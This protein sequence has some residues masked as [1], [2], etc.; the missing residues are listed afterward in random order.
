M[1]LAT[2][3]VWD[4]PRPAMCQPF[5]GTLTIKH[6]DQ[7][8]AKSTRAYR[9]IETSHPPAYYFPPE[10]ISSEC[11]K[12]NSRTSFCEWKGKAS[13]IDLCIGDETVENIGWVYTSPTASFS[14]IRGYI[15]FYASKL[16]ACFVNDEQVI[17]QDGDFYG[18]W[19]TSNLIGPF[20]GA[21]G[22]SGW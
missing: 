9:A 11:F 20:K 1:T 21:P 22:T 2:E 8:I 12:T 13:Y 4:Y 7:I 19:I 6:N 3:N 14:E 5:T 10:D 16:H 17:P 15:S 18:G